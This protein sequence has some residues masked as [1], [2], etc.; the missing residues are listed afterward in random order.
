MP[1]SRCTEVIERVSAVIDGELGPLDRL[2]FHTH[3]A[4]CPH[5]KRYYR[6]LELA[7]SLGSQPTAEDLPEDFD[8]V[9]SFVIAAV[10]PCE[11]IPPPEV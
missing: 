4:M 2:R 11:V 8:Q 1:F 7:R 10:E 5:C 9:M 6:Q 3:L